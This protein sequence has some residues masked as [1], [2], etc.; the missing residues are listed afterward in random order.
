MHHW[1]KKLSQKKKLSEGWEGKIIKY[2]QNENLVS[3][4]LN[5]FCNHLKI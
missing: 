1:I 5:C 3:F 2:K 4:I